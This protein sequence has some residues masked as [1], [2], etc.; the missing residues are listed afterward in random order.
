MF[1]VYDHHHYHP[2]ISWRHNTKTK[3]P[4]RSKCHVLGKCQCCCCL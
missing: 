4:G 1:L 3:L 2:Q